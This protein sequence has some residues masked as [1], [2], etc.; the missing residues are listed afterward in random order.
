MLR[1]SWK[2][3]VLSLGVLF[4]IVIS[5]LC[6]LSWNGMRKSKEIVKIYRVTQPIKKGVSDTTASPPSVQTN[7]ASASIQQE[8][9]KTG[10]ARMPAASNTMDASAPSDELGGQN[11]NAGSLIPQQSDKAL[12]KERSRQEIA[13]LEADI[14]RNEILLDELLNKTKNSRASRE[15]LKAELE[16]RRRALASELNALSAEEQRAYLEKQAANVTKAISEFHEKLRANPGRNLEEI[17]QLIKSM[18]QT[19]PEL[20]PEE[21]MKRDIE[22]LREYGFEPK[23]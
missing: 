10:D 23:F 16:A 22:E 19:L 17:E 5:G 14:R 11:A 12:A 4:L 1:K 13:K 21:Y 18:Q 6:Y 3:P 20:S 8:A 9:S 15:A 2:R 7:T